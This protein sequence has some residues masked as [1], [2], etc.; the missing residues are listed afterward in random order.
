MISLFFS[1]FI[2]NL[3]PHLEQFENR[4]IFDGLPSFP[5]ATACWVFTILCHHEKLTQSL[6]IAVAVAY[7]DKSTSIHTAMVW[8]VAMVW[9]FD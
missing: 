2:V 4:L 6:K 1:S 3:E 5:A 7:F 9:K 8:N